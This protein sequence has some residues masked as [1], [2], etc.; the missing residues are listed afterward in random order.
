MC[1]CYS[2]THLSKWRPVLEDSVLRHHQKTNRT[3]ESTQCRTHQHCDE[4]SLSRHSQEVPEVRTVGGNSHRTKHLN[5]SD[6]CIG[7]PRTYRHP[8]SVP[9]P[10][11]TTDIIETRSVLIHSKNQCQKS[12]QW[13]KIYTNRNI[14]TIKTE[15]SV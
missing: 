15:T 2:L 13:V 1:I 10:R 11:R 8:K 9:W 7:V 3:S 14:S 5:K 4:L 6:I 12:E